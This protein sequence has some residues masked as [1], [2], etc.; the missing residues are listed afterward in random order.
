MKSALISACVAA[1]VS[2][3]SAV[4]ATKLIDGHS[5]KNHTIPATKLTEAAVAS[6]QGARGLPGATGAKGDTGATGP[7]GKGTTFTYVIG[8]YVE[9]A[10]G[11]TGTATA[12]CP[13]GAFAL[14]GTF[15]AP[16][17]GLMLTASGLGGAASSGNPN[18]AWDV[19]AYNPTSTDL[20]LRTL[21]VCAS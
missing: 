21:A 8:A 13:A 12:Q 6:L 7:A 4:A 16:D 5:I 1:V 9:V 11:S 15:S 20:R 10:P 18:G 17:G 14:N 2:A 3:G 19:L